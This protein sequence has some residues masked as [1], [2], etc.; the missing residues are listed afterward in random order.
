MRPPSSRGKSKG[1]CRMEEKQT[2]E[3]WM[4]G[5][6]KSN[7]HFIKI[8]KRE[9]KEGANEQFVINYRLGIKLSHFYNNI[10]M[11]STQNLFFLCS[12]ILIF[13]SKLFSLKCTSQ[14][15]GKIHTACWLGTVLSNLFIRWTS[16]MILEKF[17]G[18]P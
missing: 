9:K 6:I 3:M 11:A 5:K 16:I 2:K 4:E 14:Y 13:R 7:K 15:W 17:G 18:H 1:G 10:C 8:K 12:T